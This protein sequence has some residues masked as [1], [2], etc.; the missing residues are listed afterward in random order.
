MPTD[1]PDD[2]PEGAI[3]YFDGHYLCPRCRCCDLKW[4][5]CEKCGGTGQTPPGLLYEIDPLYYDEDE[6]KPCH[7]C[8]GTGGGWVCGGGC[9][10][11][12]QH[13]PERRAV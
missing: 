8:D 5:E 6:T 4:V 13:R 11:D 2:L 10:E 3:E 1:R 7:I 9:D 12:G